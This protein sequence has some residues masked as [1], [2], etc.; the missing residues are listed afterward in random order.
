[1]KLTLEKIAE[2]MKI[3][4]GSVHYQ[5]SRGVDFDKPTQK[6]SKTPSKRV[7]SRREAVKKL[8]EVRS[9][10]TG[11]KVFGTTRRI[12]SALTWIRWSKAPGK[13]S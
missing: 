8:V 9:K 1:M 10:L 7:Q 5:L 3:P 12:R 4:V 6:P 13:E 2:L 11:S